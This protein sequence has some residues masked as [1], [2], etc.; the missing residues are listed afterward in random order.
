MRHSFPLTFA[1]YCFHTSSSIPWAWLH[2][3]RQSLLGLSP[4]PPSAAPAAA[5][6]TA[7]GESLLKASRGSGAL[8]RAAPRLQPPVSQRQGSPLGKRKAG[9]KAKHGAEITWRQERAV[10][11]QPLQGATN[12]VSAVLEVFAVWVS[13]RCP[14]RPRCGRVCHRW[15]GRRRRELRCRGTASPVWW[16]REGASLKHPLQIQTFT[17]LH[18]FACQQR[19]ASWKKAPGLQSCQ[20]ESSC[21]PVREQSRWHIWSL[22]WAWVSHLLSIRVMH[23]DPGQLHSPKCSFPP[24][25]SLPPTVRWTPHQGADG[26]V[27]HQG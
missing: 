8:L 7:E 4:R 2:L 10:V 25:S 12:L 13:V 26:E 24:S 16:G 14:S 9:R 23:W 22:G 21:L 17:R 5:T 18:S 6:A 15:R 3:H 11:A 20:S 27:A 19:A 1:I